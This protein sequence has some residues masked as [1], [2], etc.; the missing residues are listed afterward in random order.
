MGVESPV[1]VGV[2]CSVAIFYP[3]QEVAQL[4]LI[5]LEIPDEAC[6]LVQIKGEQGQGGAWRGSSKCKHIKLPVGLCILQSR[7]P[8]VCARMGGGQLHIY[9]PSYIICRNYNSVCHTG[10]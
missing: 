10:R 8:Q 2:V 1:M 4:L 5:Q 3:V 7:H 6:V 9:T